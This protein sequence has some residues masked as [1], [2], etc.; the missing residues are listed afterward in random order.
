MGRSKNIYK[1]LRNKHGEGKRRYTTIG[2]NEEVAAE[3]KV[4]VKAYSE[5]YGKMTP[6]QVIKRLIDVGLKRCDPEVFDAFIR[7]T[8]G[9]MPEPVLEIV[10]QVD[11][12]EGEVWNR[13]YFFEKDGKKIP[14]EWA[15]SEKASFSAKI[16][17]RY[18]GVREMKKNGW[19]LRDDAGNELTEEQAMEIAQKRRKHLEDV[20]FQTLIERGREQARRYNEQWA[21]IEEVPT[22]DYKYKLEKDGEIKEVFSYEMDEYFDAGWTMH[23]SDLHQ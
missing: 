17:N 11:P 1:P 6:A 18:I 12:T 10:H 21:A 16:N 15:K 7:L 3:L 20:E 22:F 23:T 13:K 8:E 5:V 2:L 4:L 9:G 14:A 19:K